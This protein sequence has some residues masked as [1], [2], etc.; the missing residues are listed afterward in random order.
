[1]VKYRDYLQ[2]NRVDIGTSGTKSYNLDYADPITELD[3]YFEATNGYTSNKAAPIEYC[4]SKIEIVDGGEVLWDLPGDVAYS[5]FCTDN[6]GCPYNEHEEA[7]GASVR[8][9]IPIRFGRYLYDEEYAFTPARFKNPQLKFTFDEATVR[10]AAVD[11]YE[12]DTW[13]FTLCVRLMEGLT[14]PGKFL[15]YRSVETFETVGTGDRRVEMPVDRTIR[16]LICKAY[17]AGVAMYTSISNHKLSENGGKF[18]PFDM[19]T[20]DFMNLHCRTFKPIDWNMILMLSDATT[21][22][23]WLGI[24]QHGQVTTVVNN[25][26]AGGQ[27]YIYSQVYARICGDGGDSQSNRNCHVSVSGWAPHNTL[28]Y[29]FGDRMKPEQWYVP[30]IDGKLDY[31]VYDGS[32]GADVDICFQQVYRF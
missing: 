19:A 16:Y 17:D 12:T 25:V 22:E 29:P 20:R 28:V 13:T 4:I 31:F 32:A 14:D 6:E 10:A 27:F 15:T 18:I 3:L 23:T 11:G 26:I 24:N 5:V 8:L 9:S 7:G 30:P 2:E 1:M 21:S